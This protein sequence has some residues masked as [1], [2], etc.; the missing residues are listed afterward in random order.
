[1]KIYGSFT[2]TLRGDGSA[3]VTHHGMLSK[4]S[5][6]GLLMDKQTTTLL[7]LVIL[8]PIGI[9]L[10]RTHL[11]TPMITHYGFWG[12]ALAWQLPASLPF[13]LSVG[14]LGPLLL[15]G[16]RELPLNQW[17]DLLVLPGLPT[18]RYLLMMLV[19]GLDL[20]L[21]SALFWQSA[22]LNTARM[23]FTTA[24]LCLLGLNSLVFVWAWLHRVVK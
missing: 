22:W 16:L 7:S 24:V 5:K 20:F 17:L 3:A 6:E 13:G 23:V 10:A 14:V 19:T 9:V 2:E 18:S 12:Q 15:L 8:Q 1:L 21:I 11:Q 4:T